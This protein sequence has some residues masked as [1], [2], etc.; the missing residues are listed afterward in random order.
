M[1]RTGC[2]TG[3]V[4]SNISHE[5]NSRSSN[6]GI[7]QSSEIESGDWHTKRASVQ[8]GEAD[9]GL[10]GLTVNLRAHFKIKNSLAT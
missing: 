5:P 4:Q 7:S 10:G 3:S 2:L 8:A 9:A 1:L 6:R